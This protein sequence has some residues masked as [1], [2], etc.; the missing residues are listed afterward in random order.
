M[1]FLIC[2]QLRCIAGIHELDKASASYALSLQ[3]C[4]LSFLLAGCKV[5]AEDG[6]RTSHPV[7]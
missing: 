3:V 5:F 4:E 6:I 1:R 7:R 2:E